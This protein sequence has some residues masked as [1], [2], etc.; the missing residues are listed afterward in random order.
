MGRFGRL[1][2][3]YPALWSAFCWWIFPGDVRQ[4]GGA[5]LSMGFK[6]RLG[7]GAACAVAWVGQECLRGWVI[8]GFPWNYLGASIRFY[9]LGYACAVHGCIRRISGCG[10]GFDRGFVDVLLLARAIGLFQ[11]CSSLV[12]PVALFVV[13][14]V[15]GH[16]A[17]ALS[18]NAIHFPLPVQPSMTKPC[19]G[20]SQMSNLRLSDLSD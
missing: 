19:F 15:L 6:K 11:L 8:T 18:K 4:A 10:L 9:L 3:G 17:E 5:I 7:W 20:M 13:V 2:F 1:L 16:V 12:G 14:L